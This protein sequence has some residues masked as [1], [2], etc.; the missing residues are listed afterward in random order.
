MKKL[1]LLLMTIL[2]AAVSAS[3]Q[4]RTVQGVVIS[5]EDNEPIVGAPVIVVGTKIGVNTDADGKFTI[6]NVPSDA[7]FLQ[8]TYVGMETKTIP[9]TS[10]EMHIVLQ[11]KYTML[12]EVVVTAMGISRSEKSLGYSVVNT[13]GFA[14]SATRYVLVTDPNEPA[15][16]FYTVN[17]DSYRDYKGT[18]YF[19]GYE[20]LIY[21]DGHGNYS[22]SDLLGGW[23]EFRAG[24]GSSYAL[25][26]NV[27]IT[28]DGTVSLVSSFLEG[29]GDG[30][31]EMTEGKFDAATKTIQWDVVYAGM[32]FHISAT[33]N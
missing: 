24:Y 4:T 25:T 6:P 20:I 16:G 11:P 22:V 12:D 27:T 10:G 29:W 14:S 30:A 5:G 3:A 2:I 33:Q 31:D 23:Y 32:P 28:A 13:D 9:I 7:K 15:T 18:V 21:G 8:L 1:F 26:G 19:G 17:N